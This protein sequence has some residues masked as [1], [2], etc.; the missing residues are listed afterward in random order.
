MRRN[1]AGARHRRLFDLTTVT[2]S[3]DGYAWRSGSSVA[4]DPGDPH[5]MEESD[6]GFGYGDVALACPAL[7]QTQRTDRAEMHSQMTRRHTMKKAISARA[8]QPY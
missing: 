8:W 3:R 6:A 2:G 1:G 7:P 5:P 4:L